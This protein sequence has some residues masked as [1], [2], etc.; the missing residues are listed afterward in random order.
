MFSLPTLTRNPLLRNIL[1]ITR[2]QSRRSP[3]RRHPNRG[4][5]AFATNAS[6]ESAQQH[7]APVPRVATPPLMEAVPLDT[8]RFAD[9]GKENLLHPILLQ[10]IIEDLKFDHMMPV[11]AATLHDLLA[12][13]IDCLAQAK[14]GTG[15]TIAFLLPAIQTLINL[16]RPPGSGVSLLV[17]SPTRE[18]AMQIAKE[19]TALLKRLPK[20]KVSFAIGGTNK[21]TEEAQILKGCDILIAT[22]G[23]LLDHL[24]DERQVE[25][26]QPRYPRPR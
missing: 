15:K 8:P 11:Q 1:T 7:A 21:N 20:Y 2:Q 4:K 26:P 9:L 19:A 18:L 23:R 24:S 25:F 14:T 16:N 12:K 17:I 6:N 5:K 3:A 10:T 22:P 13:R